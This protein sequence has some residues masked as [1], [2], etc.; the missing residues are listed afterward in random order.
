MILSSSQIKSVVRKVLLEKVGSAYFGSSF[1]EYKRRTDSGE[2][3]FDVLNDM[4]DK[5]TYV[6][7]GSTRIVYMFKDNPDVVLKVVNWAKGRDPE[8]KDFTG[9]N[10]QHMLDSNKWEANLDLQQ[11]FPDVFPRTFEVAKDYSWILSEAVDTISGY[12]ELFSI[13]GI[14]DSYFPNNKQVFRMFFVE[15]IENCVKLFQNPDN[16]YRKIIFGKNVNENTYRND[17]F[18]LSTKKDTTRKIEKQKNVKSFSREGYIDTIKR[19][20]TDRQNAKILSAM[21]DLKIPAREFSPKNLG[22][23]KITKKLVILDASLWEAYVRI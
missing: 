10:K 23:S 19:I 20:V 15:L 22:M 14:Q 6:G 9:F 21:G 5:V 4:S 1:L 12:D 13:M 3:P 2:Y 18:D 7:E 16:E 17:L 11:K 8:E